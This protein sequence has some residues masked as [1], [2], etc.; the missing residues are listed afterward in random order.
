MKQ[1]ITQAKDNISFLITALLFLTLSLIAINGVTAQPIDPGQIV[2]DIKGVTDWSQLLSLETAIYTFI[3]TVG[4]Y[5]SA[6]IPGLR[7]IDSG[8]WRVLVWAIMVIAGSLVI[9]VG[10]VWLGAI[11]YFFSTSLYEV[12][13]KW[14][15][16]SPKPQA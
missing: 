11:S 12:V 13:F 4:G 16:P 10:N 1:L 6:F 2:D 7:S 15:R 8:T 9:G 3:I 5:L 14:I